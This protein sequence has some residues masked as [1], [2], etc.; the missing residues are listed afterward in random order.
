MKC[1]PEIEDLLETLYNLTSQE[2]EILA[3]ICGEDR[4]VEDLCEEL[5]RERSTVQRYVSSLR[6]ADLVSRRSVTTD[7][8]KGR[9]FV[10]TV[11]DKETLKRKIRGRLDDWVEA[12]RQRLDEF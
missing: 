10:Y 5:D 6:K 8:G 11:R 1:P 2:A 4:T 12:K 7:E 9:Y 3:L